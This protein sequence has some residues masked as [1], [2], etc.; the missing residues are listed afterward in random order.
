MNGFGGMGAGVAKGIGP[1]IVGFWMANCLSWDNTTFNKD[2]ND[3]ELYVPVGSLIAF[4]GIS[5][6]GLLLLAMLPLLKD[7]ERA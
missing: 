5:C 4:G 6:F 3:V 2:G 1:I 7:G